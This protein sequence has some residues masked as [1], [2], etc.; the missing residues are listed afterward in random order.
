[1][2]QT[3][4]EKSKGEVI[5]DL[6]AI[7]YM[8]QFLEDSLQPGRYHR[9][10]RTLERFRDIGRMMFWAEE[11]YPLEANRILQVLF[12]AVRSG[13]THNDIRTIRLMF[14]RDRQRFDQLAVGIETAEE[15]WVGSDE[16][17]LVSSPATPSVADDEEEEDDDGEGPGPEVVNYP[18]TQVARAIETAI[19][20]FLASRQADILRLLRE[21]RNRLEVLSDGD[22]LRE[23]LRAGDAPAEAARGE[24]KEIVTWIDENRDL[25]EP[26]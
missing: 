2:L 8:D 23:G 19:D 24:F 21:I 3:M 14:R 16:P 12:A 7:K 4:V 15:G 13:Q 17:S 6:Y 20:G 25:G 5:R 1:M 9:L 22:R 11:E 26:V 10:L 18:R